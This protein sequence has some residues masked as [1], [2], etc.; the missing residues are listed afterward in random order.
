MAAL[1]QQQIRADRSRD[2]AIAEFLFRLLNKCDKIEETKEKKDIEKTLKNAEYY[3]EEEARIAKEEAR[4][5]AELKEA[6]ANAKTV[7]SVEMSQGQMVED[8]RIA[9]D[10]RIPV[11]FY[12][13]HGGNIPSP[14]EVLDQIVKISERRG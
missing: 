6:C 4:I 10:C 8:L 11:E 2:I 9:L 7:L 14:A 13:R 5:E 12:G 3:K 1:L